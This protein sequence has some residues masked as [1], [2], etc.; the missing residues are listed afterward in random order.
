ML[1][2]REFKNYMLFL[3]LTGM[4]CDGNQFLC[5]N[6]QCVPE[7]WICDGEPDCRDQSDE[8]PELCAEIQNNGSCYQGNSAVTFISS[9]SPCLFY[10]Q[11][12]IKGLV[13]AYFRHYNILLD[14]NIN[15][16]MYYSIK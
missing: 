9:L 15:K 4:E 3:V 12:Q 1:P 5:K 10:S 8:L 7:K 16:R 2:T 14:L 6:K 13:R 11:T